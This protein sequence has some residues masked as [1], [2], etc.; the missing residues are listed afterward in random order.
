MQNSEETLSREE[1]LSYYRQVGLV[2]GA[3]YRL[4]ATHCA[5]VLKAGLCALNDSPPGTNHHQF[6]IEFYRTLRTSSE[7]FWN[8]PDRVLFALIGAIVP[9]NVPDK[10]FVIGVLTVH[11]FA[12]AVEHF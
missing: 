9:E 12:N 3:I 11:G 1:T 10:Y 6:L 8:I 4:T 5:E 7:I 2:P